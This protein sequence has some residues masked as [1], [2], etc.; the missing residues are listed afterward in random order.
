MQP[1]RILVIEDN[2]ADVQMLRLALDQQEEDYEREILRDGEEAL[3]FVRERRTDVQKAGPCVI[4]LDVQLPRYDGMAVLRAI[5]EAPALEHSRVVVLSGLMNPRQEVEI[6]SHK[7]TYIRKPSTLGELSELAAKIFI[8]C[9]RSS[10]ATS[11]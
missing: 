3:R 9:K 1:A 4:L 11:A 10:P 5:R 8:I 6:A 7:A 2:E